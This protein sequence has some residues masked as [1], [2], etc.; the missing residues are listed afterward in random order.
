MISI[1]FALALLLAALRVAPW[2]KWWLLTIWSL[3]AVLTFI[4]MFC[5]DDPTVYAVR[6]LIFAGPLV[7]ALYL[8][9]RPPLRQ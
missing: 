5:A 6:T 9:A 3:P 8:R 2:M 7:L 4:S 1:V